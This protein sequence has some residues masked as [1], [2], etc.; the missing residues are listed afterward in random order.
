MEHGVNE[1]LL[2]EIGVERDCV[3]AEILRRPFGESSGPIND[4]PLTF[5]VPG[6]VHTRKCFTVDGSVIS[7]GATRPGPWIVILT[8]SP[9]ASRSVGTHANNQKL[10]QI[11]RVVLIRMPL[12][13]GRP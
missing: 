3:D 1:F 9:L 13:R 6:P 2:R 4:E 10:N 11:V 8:V 5:V 12:A 7:I